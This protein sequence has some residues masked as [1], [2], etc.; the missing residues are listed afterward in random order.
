MTLTRITE[1]VS[2]LLKAYEAGHRQ[3]SRGEI[4]DVV[5]ITYDEWGETPVELLL[6][7]A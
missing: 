6:W 5:Q 4:L 3:T 1:N 7:I 2:A